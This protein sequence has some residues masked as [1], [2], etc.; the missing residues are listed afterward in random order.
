MP[1]PYPDRPATALHAEHTVEAV[2]RR[3]RG[4]PALSRLRDAVYGAI[5]GAVTTFAVVAGVAGAG[6]DEAIVVIL[7]MANLIAD[8]FSMAVSN[9]L[10]ARVEQAQR[11]QARAQEELHIELVPE[12]E[13]E[14][15]RQIL[16]T[17]GFAGQQLEDAVGVI[18]SDREVWIDLMMTDELG[19]SR[20]QLSPLRAAMATFLAFIVVGFLPLGS[21][22]LDA[23][24]GIDVPSPFLWSTV[25]TAAGFLIVGVVRARVTDQHRGRSAIETLLLGGGA[26][27]LAYIVGVLLAGVA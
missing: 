11:K 25:L 21:Y 24:T 2:R 1:N 20:E 13:R 10:G 14:E 26:A 4:G 17:K 16:M 3:I 15:V 5:D 27:A 19:F 12:G 18:T 9:Y 8:G 6:L 22:V 7:G 23:T